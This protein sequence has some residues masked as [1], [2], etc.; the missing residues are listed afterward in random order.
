LTILVKIVFY[1][2]GSQ[3]IR[4]K[5]GGVAAGRHT[6]F[7]AKAALP[8]QRFTGLGEEENDKPSQ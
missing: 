1:K 3:K 5:S 4:H 6:G 7:P 8:N 2:H